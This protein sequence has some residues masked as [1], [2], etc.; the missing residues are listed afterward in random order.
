[1][2]QSDASGLRRSM[3]VGRN[4]VISRP[5][6]ATQPGLQAGARLLH[7]LVHAPHGGAKVNL[8]PAHLHPELGVCSGDSSTPASLAW[9]EPANSTRWLATS[10]HLC[11]T[12]LE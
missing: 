12:L 1:M 4:S 10:G 8:D 9:V 2:L 3:M 7:A 6:Q 5:G 11:A